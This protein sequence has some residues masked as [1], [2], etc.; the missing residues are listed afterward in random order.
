MTNVKLLR[1]RINDSGYKI[2]FIAHKC[3]ISYQGFLPKMQG[4]REFN[5]KEIAAIKSLLNL[6]NEEVED[7]FFATE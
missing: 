5:Q 4:E 6:S 1:E 3:G 2:A 7:I